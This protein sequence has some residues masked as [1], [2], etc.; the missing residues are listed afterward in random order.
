MEKT[1]REFLNEV[2]NALGVGWDDLAALASI[3]PL[4]LKS[5]RMPDE[6]ETGTGKASSNYRQMPELA[7]LSIQRVFDD[8]KKNLKKD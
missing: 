5:Y 8:H 3:K 6:T 7:R 1:Q 4:A 2:K